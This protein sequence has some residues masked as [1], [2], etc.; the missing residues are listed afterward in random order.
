MPTYLDVAGQGHVDISEEF[1]FKI[2]QG[3]RRRIFMNMMA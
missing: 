3:K 2:E 1:F